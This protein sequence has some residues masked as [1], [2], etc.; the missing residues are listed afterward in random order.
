RYPLAVTDLAEYVSLKFGKPYREVHKEIASLIKELGTEDIDKIC[1]ELSRKLGVSSEELLSAIKPE[2][3]LNA[4]RVI[5]SPNPEFTLMLIE[6][7]ENVLDRDYDQ[8]L[9]LA[10]ELGVSNEY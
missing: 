8:Y 6:R 5:G 10:K 1:C 3:V 7:A 9:T 4:R 2:N